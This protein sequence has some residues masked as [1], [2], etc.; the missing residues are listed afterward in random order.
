M[1]S[2]RT[3]AEWRGRQSCVVDGEL[4]RSMA[5]EVVPWTVARVDGEG[6]CASFRLEGIGVQQP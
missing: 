4:V 1:G 3:C 6:G 5:I 2:C